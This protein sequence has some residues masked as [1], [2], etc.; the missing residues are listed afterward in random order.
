MIESYVAALEA[1]VP[2]G[3]GTDGDT[4]GAAARHL[5]DRWRAEDRGYHDETHLA[6]MLQRLGELGH[7]D[8]GCVL[9][10]WYH[11]AVYTGRSGEDERASADLARRELTA[12]GAP[13]RAVDRVR[14]LVLVTLDHRPGDD[15]HAR[16]VVDADLAILAADPDRYAAYLAGVRRDFHRFDD[17]AFTAGRRAFVQQTLARERL[18][19]TDHGR[20]AWEAAAR[21]NLAAELDPPVVHR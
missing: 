7:D 21:R 1:V 13:P 4:V 16:A 14:R 8:P 18:F 9:A 5:L 17:A 12:L 20:T 15:P 2:D 3:Q 10:A 6:E 19:H 11:D